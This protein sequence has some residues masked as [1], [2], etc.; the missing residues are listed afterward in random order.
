VETRRVA[1]TGVGLVS[2]LGNDPDTF[3]DNL[4]A[5]ISGLRPYPELGRHPVGRAEFAPECLFTR[6]ELLGLDR[7][8]QFAVVASREAAESAGLAAVDKERLGVFYG[9]GTR[10]AATLEASSGSDFASARIL[11]RSSLVM[12]SSV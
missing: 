3:F 8:S 6:T 5:G 1:V 12:G 9:T 11:G 10:G 4:V 7:V 2:C